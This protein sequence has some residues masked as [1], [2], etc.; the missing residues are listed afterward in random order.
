MGDNN[1]IEASVINTEDT[2]TVEETP[3]VDDNEPVIE[4]PTS[5]EEGETPETNFSKEENEDG[6]EVCPECGKVKSECHCDEKN[7]DKKD[8]YVL[9]E[10]P[11][12][13]ELEQK[14]AALQESFNALTIE[15]DALV[16][17]NNMLQASNGQLNEFKLA[18]ERKE[19]ENMINNTFYMLNDV[20]KEDVI[21][22][23]S[24]DRVFEPEISEEE[25]TKKVSGWNK[26]VKY[27]YGWAKED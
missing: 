16:E 21:K 1:T 26:A 9:E 15:R 18:V 19:K 8:K 23:S 5:I 4:N 22:N 3:V 25:R 12:Y 2:T 24:I 17:S 7:E 20:D 11:E 13:M 14:Y 6:E 10:I 27:S